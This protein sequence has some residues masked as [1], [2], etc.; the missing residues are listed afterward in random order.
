MMADKEKDEL[1]PNSPIHTRVLQLGDHKKQAIETKI[2][3]PT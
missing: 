3:Q 2:G 1:K